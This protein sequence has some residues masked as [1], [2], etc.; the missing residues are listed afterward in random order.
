MIVLDAI[1]T[2]LTRY[3]EFDFW[4]AHWGIAKTFGAKKIWQN[5]LQ[6]LVQSDLAIKLRAEN[7]D[8]DEKKVLSESKNQ[9]D[10]YPTEDRFN[11]RVDAKVWLKSHG[12]DIEK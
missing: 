11:K 10:A 7:K 9:A 2:H 5:S 8:W 1:S 4:D 3:V 6:G 12:I